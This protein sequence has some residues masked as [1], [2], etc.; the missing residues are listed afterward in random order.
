MIYRAEHPNPQFERQSWQCLNGL[1]EFEMDYPI[2]GE[3]RGL[4]KAD[5]A[6]HRQ[7][8]VPFCVES[9]LSGIGETDF[10]NSVW[11][12][13]TLTVTAAQLAG[14][15]LLHIGAADYE[16]TVYVNEKKVGTHTGGY[17][18][19][20][21]DITDY[22]T[23]GDNTVVIHCADDTRS[24][25]IPAGKQSI[26]HHSW[27][28]AYTRTTGIWQS[29][30]VEYVPTSYIKK[31]KYHTDAANAVLTV[32]AELIGSGELT[33]TA[34]FDGR[35]VG[36]ATCCSA[37][38]NATLSIPLTETHL[39]EVGKGDLYDLTLTYGDDTVQ[40]YFGL[41]TVTVSGNRVLINGKSVFQRLVL[42]QGFYPD[43]IYTAPTEEAL[44]GDIQRALAFGFNGARLHQ[45]VF[46]PRFLYHCDR[47]GYIVWGE[48]PNGWLDHTYPEAIYSIL[49]EWLEAV[50][51]DCNHPAIITWC[52]FNES[53]NR[54]GRQQYDGL[55]KLLYRATKIADPTRPC[56]DTSGF[57]HVQ[58]DIFDIHDYEQ[59]P[60]VFAAHYA[61]LSETH[62][63][64]DFR[65]AHKDRQ[66]YDGKMPFCVSEYGGSS[67]N[68]ESGWG[69]GDA[70]TTQKAFLERFRALTNTL[71]ENENIYAMCYTQLTD[72]E[73]EQNGLYYY[74]RT[75][76]FDP[77]PFKEILSKKAAIED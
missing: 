56:I 68:A 41:R 25:F 46:E 48:Y 63:C 31:V 67:W 45:K 17:V 32:N 36:T 51:R 19:F 23:A 49:P 12:R 26:M 62:N 6:Y 43:G 22:V 53:A 29:V 30:W 64:G 55:F 37:G 24:R 61:C 58:T 57:C 34:Y 77:A 74:D 28:C 47:L 3:A 40:S 54:D 75:P 50:D 20:T 11:Y 13:R 71:L 35:A 59:D 9:K 33:A 15:V 69:Y 16:T 1:W 66:K 38:G 65:A 7:I 5:A 2:S 52:P 42:D 27:G 73:Q 4:F 39:W 44:V 72:I 21:F 70:V 10:I 60:E 8:N 18:S 14:R 76:K